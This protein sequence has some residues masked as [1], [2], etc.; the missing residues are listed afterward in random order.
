MTIDDEGNNKQ[1]CK[2]GLT[3]YEVVERQRCFKIMRRSYEGAWVV[4]LQRNISTA[5]RAKGVHK[6]QL[7]TLI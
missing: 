4:G 2:M 5:L 1:Q 3:M 6:I 7:D